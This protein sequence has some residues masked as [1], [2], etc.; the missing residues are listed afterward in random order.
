MFISRAALT[1]I[2]TVF[3][4]TSVS[5]LQAQETPPEMRQREIGLRLNGLDN[6][7]LIYKYHLKDNKYRRLRFVAGNIT[8]QNTSFT[9][10]NVS[11]GGAIGSEKR[12]RIT[13]KAKLLHGPEFS[14]GFNLTSN[15]NRTNLSLSPGANYVLGFLYQPNDK[16]NISIEGAISLSANY[17]FTSGNDDWVDAASIALEFNSSNVALNVV[18]RFE[19][20]RKKKKTKN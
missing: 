20:K 6:F 10:F 13:D 15:N 8:V 1:T 7:G 3:F 16:F 12:I 18:Y 17:Q 9:S 2:A 4:M 5:V 19:S 11:F 14:G